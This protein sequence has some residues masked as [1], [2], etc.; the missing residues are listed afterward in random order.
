MKPLNKKLLVEKI[1][2]EVKTETGIIVTNTT[3]TTNEPEKGI[4]K[5]V[6][7]EIKNIKKGDTVIFPKN[8]YDNITINTKPYILI[9]YN[10]LMGIL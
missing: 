8:R 1:N 4:V 5:E 3:L 9:D 2:E 7:E 10:V 6:A